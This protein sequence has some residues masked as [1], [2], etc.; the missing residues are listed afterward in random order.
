M[1]NTDARTEFALCPDQAHP[2]AVQILQ[3]RLVPL[4]G[5]RAM[6][7]RRTLPHR[8]RSFVG[9]WCFVDHY[10]PDEVSSTG[11][12][13]VPPHPHTGLQTVSWLFDGEIEH[14]DSTGVHA[15]VAPGEVNLMTAGQ[16]IAHSEVSTAT[17]TTLRGVQ[18][19]VVLPAAD[20]HVT[21]GFERY[22]VPL[23]EVAP[24]VRA[25]VFVG[26]LAGQ[27]SPIHTFTP[28]TGAEIHL[29][30]GTRWTVEVSPEHEHALLIDSG[31]ATLCGAALA[32]GEL[33][34]VD[35]GRRELSLVAREDTRALLL[36]GTPFE[37][38]VVMWWNFI[39]ATHQ[40]I[41]LVREQWQEHA[42]RFGE[43]PGYSGKSSRL[44]A[45]PMPGVRLRPR[46]SRGDS[47]GR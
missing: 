15:T 11:G 23:A 2:D 37:E 43:V 36:G 9:A 31:S 22:A 46:G 24:G 41:E 21:A 44:P 29:D 25:R 18:L 27:V 8:E 40:E 38:E 17:T 28:L 12:M 32:E 45:P 3:P 14:R 30:A 33:G 20:R 4:G 26:E 39:A 6:T 42:A 19:W 7:V 5:P 1:T 34:I 13:D 16:G 10:G 35:A 47:P